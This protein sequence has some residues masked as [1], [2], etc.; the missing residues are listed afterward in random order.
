ML[1]T[2]DFTATTGTTVVLASGATTGDLIRTESFYVSSVLNAI[3]ATAGSVSTSYLVDGS[4]T[5]AK[6]STNVAGNGPAF[7][8]YAS[9][10]ITITNATWTKITFDLE[11]FDTNNNF[12]S[13]R[14][15]PTVAGYYQ[16]N[17]SWQAGFT[18]SF[19]G[20]AFYKNGS[21][22][23]YGTFTPATS[24]GVQAG[25]SSLIYFNGTTDY[26]EV[27]AYQ[28]TGS[29]QAISTSSSA[30]TWFN[31]AMVRSA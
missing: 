29:S 14:F 2:A 20:V 25:S 16:V 1:G 21:L 17:S 27:Y 12:A 28:A 15:T 10:G 8:A 3:P 26:L 22:F 4:V 11:L 19:G 18:T 24:V 9:S 31:G 30:L 13:S 23:Q 5:Q 6:F 7:S